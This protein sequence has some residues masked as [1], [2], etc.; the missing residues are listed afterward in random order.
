V[1]QRGEGDHY[2]ETNSLGPDMAGLVDS[3][4]DYLLAWSAQG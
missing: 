2:E 3:W 4:T 1:D